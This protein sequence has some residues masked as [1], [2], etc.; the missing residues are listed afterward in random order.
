MKMLTF[1]SLFAGIGGLDLGLERAGMTCKWQVEND[2]YATKV[3]EKHW[4]AVA[5][6]GDVRECG[7]A[8]LAPVDLICGGFPCQDV[9][10]AGKRA[11]L[12]GKRTTLWSEFI[13]IIG[14]LE[15]RW[16]L[17]ENVPGLLSSDSGRFFGHVLRDL[18]AFRYDAEWDCIPAVAVG[19]PHRRYRVFIV[20]HARCR[21]QSQC[22]DSE[23]LFARRDGPTRSAN[24]TSRPSCESPPVAYANGARQQQSKGSIE[25]ERGWTGD[26]G[27]T[28]ADAKRA[29][30]AQRQGHQKAGWPCDEPARGG[31][32][33]IFGGAIREYATTVGAEQWAVEPDVGRVA[34]G[35]PS[36]V[37]RLRCLG[38]AVVPQVAEWIG[39]RIMENI[40]A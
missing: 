11:G 35:V 3:L 32:W 25:K 16:V 23:P 39:R 33:P 5:R 27:E 17:A 1:G 7:I 18:A 38:N 9:S 40:D 20:A 36:R 10:F 24:K 12:K 2:E 31:V 29:G 37:D 28:M 14:A 30:L 13:R 19:A 21:V 26:G 15:P 34:H 4:P 22:G 8:N 6:Y